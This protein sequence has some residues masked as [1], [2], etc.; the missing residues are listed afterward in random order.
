MRLIS[1]RDLAARV[2]VSA[3]LLDKLIAAGWLEAIRV[4]RQ[5]FVIED[6]WER[7]VGQMRVRPVETHAGVTPEGP[8]QQA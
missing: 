8:R 2:G 3:W 7:Y 5:K 4:G 6:S 1:L